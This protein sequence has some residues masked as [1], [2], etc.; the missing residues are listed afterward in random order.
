MMRWC[1]RVT[2]DQVTSAGFLPARPRLRREPARYADLTMMGQWRFC[3]RRSGPFSPLVLAGT[4]GWTWRLERPEQ[5]S[6]GRQGQVVLFVGP[7]A[8]VRGRL[9]EMIGRPFLPGSAAW[10]FGKT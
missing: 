5:G 4:L 6:G 7:E 2:V 10:G 8:G 1:G 3:F 9:G